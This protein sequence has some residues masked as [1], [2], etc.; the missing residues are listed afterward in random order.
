MGNSTNLYLLN[1]S[2]GSAMNRPT[3]NK[4]TLFGKKGETGVKT[5]EKRVET[6]V[7]QGCNLKK[8]VKSH[9]F[10]NNVPVYTL[11]SL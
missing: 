1:E 2:T 5:I 4:L 6:S 10:G 3:K 11:F 8:G 7:N 9:L